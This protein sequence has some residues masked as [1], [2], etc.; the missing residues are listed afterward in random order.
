MKNQGQS[1]VDVLKIFKDRDQQI[2]NRTKDTEFGPSRRTSIAKNDD[3]LQQGFIRNTPMKMTS[4]RRPI[5]RYQTLFLGNYSSCYNFGH[6]ATNYK[7]NTVNS[8]PK[9]FHGPTYKNTNQFEVL[10]QDIECFACHN[11]GHKARNYRYRHYK[12]FSLQQQ[13]IHVVAMPK[14]RL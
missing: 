2:S 5:G 7:A 9:E 14:P 12:N 13:F 8:Q 4:A 1:Y 6:K 11:F 10:I 3:H